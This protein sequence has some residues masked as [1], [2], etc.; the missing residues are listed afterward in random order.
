[1][2]RGGGS[3][4]SKPGKVLSI[5]GMCFVEIEY[6]LSYLLTKVI[7]NESLDVCEFTL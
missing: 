1:M 3:D 2:D 7:I 4:F 6:C 5:P